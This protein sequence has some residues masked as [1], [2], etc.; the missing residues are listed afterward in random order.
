MI[1]GGRH[2]RC[3][4]AAA[5]PALLAGALGAVLSGCAGLSPEQ[6]A[7][8]EASAAALRWLGESPDL[9]GQNLSIESAAVARLPFSG[10]K[11]YSIKAADGRGGLH[12]VAF[13]V[14]LRRIDLAA[15]LADER[16]QRLQALGALDGPVAERL[17]AAP[18]EPL[19]VVLWLADVAPV[20]LPRF[21]ARG[22]GLAAERIETLY[23]DVERERR[24][25]VERLLAPVLERVRAF[26]RKAQSGAPAPM[27]VARL[28]A[29]ALREL[30]QDRAIDR[31]YLDLPARPELVVAKAATGITQLQQQGM[32]GQGIRVAAINVSG[33]L[34]EAGSLVLRPVVQDPLFMCQGQVD[35]HATSVVGAMIARRITIFGQTVGEE[36]AAPGLTV[37]AAGSCTTNS[38]ELMDLSSRAADW[39]ARVFNLSW[40]L[41]TRSMLGAV[42]RFYDDLVFN[43][44]RSVVKSAGNRPCL[45]VGGDAVTTPGLAYN[46]V[47]VGG[48]D[49]RQTFD[50]GDDVIDVCAS[51]GNPISLH[52]D[53]EKPELAAPSVDV[54]VVTAGPANLARVTGTSIAAPQVTAAAALLIEGNSRLSIWPEIVRALLMATATHNIEGSRRLSDRDGAGGVRADTARQLLSDTGRWDGLHYRCDSATP[55]LLHLATLQASPRTRHRVVL[56]WSTDPSDSHYASQPSADIDL[57]VVDGNGR[58]VASSMSFDN[59]FEIVEFDVMTAG[60]FTLRAHKFR[61]DR[62]VWLG[63]AWHTAPAAP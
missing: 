61:C 17:K 22:E 26:D 1:A 20:S 57:S 11:V 12:G 52:G 8:N 21:Q 19:Q 59:S 32:L 30:A 37:R 47:T 33:G 24:A 51:F 41:D 49:N 3:R 10:R 60:S 42:D 18:K 35:A 28:E 48:Y 9:K 23:D 2:R 53:R 54:E 40:G 5:W 14:G 36:G 56:S 58:T 44:W 55:T 29:A 43:R 15:A 31:I 6:K 46:V 16:R 4:G 13:E 34:V 39:G 27:I 38:V 25:T 63:W 62:P 50:L 45:P 7:L